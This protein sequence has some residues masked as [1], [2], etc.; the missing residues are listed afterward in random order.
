M[1]KQEGKVSYLKKDFKKFGI[2]LLT[3]CLIITF[4]PALEVKAD[5]ENLPVFTVQ[6]TF[7]MYD[8]DTGKF[9]TRYQTLVSGREFLWLDYSECC[10]GKGYDVCDVQKVELSADGL[11]TISVE[12]QSFPV[13]NAI[14]LG[15]SSGDLF[16]QGT[17]LD[18]YQAD[19]LKVRVI[20]NDGLFIESDVVLNT[21]DSYSKHYSTKCGTY[22]TIITALNYSEY[23]KEF[24]GDD[25]KLVDSLPKYFDEE[26]NKVYVNVDDLEGG[27][28]VPEL[29]TQVSLK[30]NESGEVTTLVSKNGV[31]ITDDYRY[32]SKFIP[33]VEEGVDI[34][35]S[36]TVEDF[37][38][39]AYGTDK[40]FGS[41]SCFTYNNSPLTECNSLGGYLYSSLANPTWEEFYK[42]MKD[43]NS[44]LNVI[45]NF[46]NSVKGYYPSI[47]QITI[48]NK[49]FYDDLPSYIK[50][51]YREYTTITES[52]YEEIN[53]FLT[54]HP[55][56]TYNIDFYYQAYDYLNPS[57]EMS[58]SDSESLSKVYDNYPD[59]LKCVTGVKIENKGKVSGN[60]LDFLQYNY[61]SF[62]DGYWTF[63]LYP[64][65]FTFDEIVNRS[66]GSY[67]SYNSYKSS[68]GK[69]NS[70]GL[71][72]RV[73]FN[74]IRVFTSDEVKDV[75][76]V[77]V[78]GDLV[79]TCSYSKSKLRSLSYSLDSDLLDKPLI[80]SSDGV[81]S[82]NEA[83]GDSS[84]NYSTFCIDLCELDDSSLDLVLNSI[85]S[86]ASYVN[87]FTMDDQVSLSKIIYS[88]NSSG[89]FD[90]HDSIRFYRTT[91]S[92]NKDVLDPASKSYIGSDFLSRA[93][94]LKYSS[95]SG[96]K[97]SPLDLTNLNYDYFISGDFTFVSLKLPLVTLKMGDDIY[98]NVN[99]FISKDDFMASSDYSNYFK[100]YAQF[101]DYNMTSCQDT[102]EY[103]SLVGNKLVLNDKF[104]DEFDL[105]KSY[106][107]VVQ[108]AALGGYSGTEQFI[109]NFRNQP[110]NLKVSTI[111]VY[112]GDMSSKIDYGLT[113]NKWNDFGVSGEVG[114]FHDYNI[115]YYEWDYAEIVPAS[116]PSEPMNL[117]A[118]L[119]DD[120]IKVSWDVP[121]N[122]GLGLNDDGSSKVDDVVKV[123]NYK[124][125]VYKV[126]DSARSST[127]VKEDVVNSTRLNTDIPVSDKGTYRVLISASNL[128]GE[129]S[130]STL[131][132]NN[133][134]NSKPKPD[135]DPNPVNPDPEPTLELASPSIITT[136]SDV[137]SITM[138]WDYKGEL[139]PE[140][141]KVA[142][143]E[144][145]T[146]SELDWN[147]VS[148]E[149][150]SKTFTN[151]KSNTEYEVYVKAYKG[152]DESAYDFRVVT[153]KEEL[154]EPT[155][156]DDPE[157][158]PSE[159][160]TPSDDPEPT[161]SED[162]EPSQ[163][164]EDPQPDEP[165][166]PPSEDPEPSQEPVNLPK[167]L[168]TE[169][170][171]AGT[172]LNVKWEYKDLKVPNCFEVGVSEE[173][174]KLPNDW[175]TVDSDT[176][177]YEF[178]DL[179]SGTKYYVFVRAV[180]D[181]GVTDDDSDGV[182]KSP[183]IIKAE[184]E[185]QP[186]NGE[187]TRTGDASNSLAVARVFVAALYILIGV[188]VYIFKNHRKENKTD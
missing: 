88:L 112:N 62:K 103:G 168:I 66:K 26:S 160:P 48:D 176:R 106:S 182:T 84:F 40:L 152:S 59:Y 101:R 71:Y 19:N 166:V 144:V 44:E 35:Q 167:P 67:S 121:S 77:N 124:V 159:E 177:D 140:G 13:I 20:F 181:E 82:I 127:L 2:L 137:S 102:N 21:R 61:D 56:A 126:D 15:M 100:K 132:I 3:F 70:D 91:F 27:I 83:L 161:P 165:T 114:D 129:G 52:N 11:E 143:K 41:A 81:I 122:Q 139:K 96:S 22:D 136:S 7:S 170:V 151:L 60:C 154:I 10:H 17:R 97:M 150:F 145:G 54:N 9:I 72:G 43:P 92:Y 74:S 42:Q 55:E 58:N 39:M 25:S 79:A 105:G 128:I 24:N 104:F 31:N 80:Y 175:V 183:S 53:T 135:P 185:A 37:P 123:D 142:I 187:F 111:K 115:S 1:K 46:Y 49:T 99:R 30:D 156:S 23:L 36:L 138:D 95:P 171:T 57:V 18:Y 180:F 164:P 186:N 149:T 28:T 125:S 158:T 163:E 169:V 94:D 45:N 113:F 32:A 47:Y 85:F 29:T 131:L 109:L 89:Y 75:V 162:P 12:F 4:M 153:T 93:F 148:N 179:N 33:R 174:T 38:S 50:N 117:K 78:D 116:A 90:T 64:K 51:D 68:I 65:P 172:T 178:K 157:P 87:L 8:P 147:T 141:Y 118:S 119:E 63:D 108:T 86:Y 76:N 133:E 130:Q 34:Y 155:P 184:K 173:V 188:G 5:N 69:L 107:L 146:D 134:N 14:E 73:Y 6:P 98:Q 120:T 16:V 110:N